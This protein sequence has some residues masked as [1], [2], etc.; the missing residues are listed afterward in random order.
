VA[1][2]WFQRVAREYKGDFLNNS[3]LGGWNSKV[4]NVSKLKFC[5][6]E[7]VIVSDSYRYC[8]RNNRTAIASDS[9][10]SEKVT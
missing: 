1:S 10:R 3:I 7:L 6:I 4:I 5:H 8:S 9:Y 2:N